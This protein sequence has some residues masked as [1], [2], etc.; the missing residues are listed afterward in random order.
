MKKKF[1]I[2]NFV[3]FIL[4]VF[5][6]FSLPPFNFFFINFFTLSIFFIFLVKRLKKEKKKFFFFYGWFFGFGFFLT[7]LYWITISLTFDENLNFWRAFINHPRSTLKHSKTKKTA[8]SCKKRWFLNKKIP[9]RAPWGTK[10][11]SIEKGRVLRTSLPWIDQGSAA[12][13]EI[14]LFVL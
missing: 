14:Y 12:S 1:I 6:S 13:T 8:F 10:G 9:A 7:N 11:I 4:G 2:E 5:S 3:L